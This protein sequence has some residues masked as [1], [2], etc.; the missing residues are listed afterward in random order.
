[1]YKFEL[2]ERGKIVIAIVLVLLILVLPAVILALKAMASQPPALPDNSPDVSAASPPAPDTAPSPTTPEPSPPDNGGFVPPEPSP[3]DG[4]NP[5]PLRPIG[6][7]EPSIDV[8]EQTLSFYFPLEANNGLDRETLS[9]LDAF[10]GLPGNIPRN[11]IAISTPLLP[12]DTAGSFTL[13]MTE[14]FEERGVSSQRLAY[15][16]DPDVPLSDYF[17]VDLYYI[18]PTNPK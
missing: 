7:P 10:L 2:T 13:V 4:G 1:M 8:A 16:V 18:T 3:S 9:V 14:T 6:V 12:D 11:I 5:E 15:I 17:E